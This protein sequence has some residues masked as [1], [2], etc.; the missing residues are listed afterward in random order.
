MEADDDF[1]MADQESVPEVHE[2]PKQPTGQNPILQAAEEAEM[3]ASERIKTLRRARGVRQGRFTKK[4]NKL[5]TSTRGG[6][7]P[8]HELDA[9]QMK[10][11]IEEAWAEYKKAHEELLD[12]L[13]DPKLIQAEEARFE[14]QEDYKEQAS[15]YFY[16]VLHHS[17]PTE[18]KAIGKLT[19]AM[20]SLEG[21]GRQKLP[22]LKLPDFDGKD[23]TVFYTFWRKFSAMVDARKD[24]HPA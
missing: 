6:K 10:K 14:E 20:E 9:I 18:D 21:V 15:A 13:E 8:L 1:T 5:N 16:R 7:T 12:E 11:G 4:F 2:V 17:A 19:R 23:I 3:D 24:I 22:E